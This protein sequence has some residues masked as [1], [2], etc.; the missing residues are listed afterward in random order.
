[1]AS[2]DELDPTQTQSQNN[3][4]HNVWLN[5][6]ND[7]DIWGRLRAKNKSMTSFGKFEFCQNH[8]QFS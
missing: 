5:D 2:D 3:T 4:E 7:A 1:M 6:E 8:I